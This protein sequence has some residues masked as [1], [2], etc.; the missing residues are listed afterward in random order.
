MYHSDLVL[1]APDDNGTPFGGRTWYRN[2]DFTGYHTDMIVFEL[3]AFV[4]G[5]TGLT[6]YGN[7]LFGCSMGGAGSLNILMTYP[8]EFVGAAPFNAPTEANSCIRYGTCHLECLVDA[9]MCELVWTSPGVAYNP[10]VLITS[11]SLLSSVGYYQPVALGI[12]EK[13]KEDG[14][15]GCMKESSAYT[16]NHFACVMATNS[17]RL[18]NSFH[19]EG[20]LDKDQKAFSSSL[21]SFVYA[22]DADIGKPAGD[23]FWLD[24]IWFVV[25]TQ[26]FMPTHNIYTDEERND[27][28]ATM[29]GLLNTM[30]TW[31][32]DNTPGILSTGSDGGLYIFMSTDTNDDEDHGFGILE[33]AHRFVGLLIA[34]SS[35][36]GSFYE[37]RYGSGGH[38]MSVRDFKTAIQFFSDVSRNGKNDGTTD[39]DGV[40]T[41]GVRAANAG[42]IPAIAG[43]IFN[44]GCPGY[45]LISEVNV[46][47][48]SAHAILN[49]MA[50][51]DT[52]V[53][54]CSSG[55]PTF[56]WGNWD[57]GGCDTENPGSQ[58]FSYGDNPVDVDKFKGKQT[59]EG[60]CYRSK[61]RMLQL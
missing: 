6:S 13:V 36:Q 61:I 20:K 41:Y 52:H 51:S 40:T 14:M 3:P 47:Q 39:K 59:D 56:D 33:M 1:I 43:R 28:C 5:S 9:F 49:Y 8:T 10:F 4:T 35:S 46:V 45:L 53:N 34:D 21:S 37:D 32:L 42:I 54:E 12:A 23:M 44:D 25:V 7:A 38:T 60:A 16:C 22:S 48:Q 29:Y 31:R 24:P 27:N 26:G 30:P 58:K 2:S 50:K 55:R 11:G 17:G 57:C 15:A 18:H 19:S